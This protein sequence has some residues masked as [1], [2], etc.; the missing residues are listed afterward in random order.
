MN[1]PPSEEVKEDEKLDF[2]LGYEWADVRDDADEGDFV[3][4]ARIDLRYTHA[5]CHNVTNLRVSEIRYP[6]EAFRLYCSLI[7]AII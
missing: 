1:K 7:C 4:L 6:S 3:S 5:P 2:A